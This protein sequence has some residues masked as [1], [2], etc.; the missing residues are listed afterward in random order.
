MWL[1]KDSETSTQESASEI[2][3]DALFSL[4]DGSHSEAVS[5]CL[6]LLILAALVC[7]RAA[8]CP[9]VYEDLSLGVYLRW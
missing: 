9:L 3:S 1:K 7:C 2:G 6:P 5:L 4:G 8:G